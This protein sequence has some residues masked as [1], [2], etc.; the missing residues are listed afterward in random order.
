MQNKAPTEL[1]LR[2]HQQLALNLS[3]ALNIQQYIMCVHLSFKEKGFSAWV[4]TTKH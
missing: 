3:G 4:N 2:K 1:A